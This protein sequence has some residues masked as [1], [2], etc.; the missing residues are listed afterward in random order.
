M[1]GD[2]RLMPEFTPEERGRRLG[3]LLVFWSWA[4]VLA[5]GLALMIAIPLSELAR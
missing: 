1:A 2:G 4:A 3:E 5:V